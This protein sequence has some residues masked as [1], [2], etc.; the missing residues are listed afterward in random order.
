MR[1]SFACFHGLRRSYRRLRADYSRGLQ[2]RVGDKVKTMPI[3]VEPIE[4]EE[5][6]GEEHH[7]EGSAGSAGSAEAKH[8]DDAEEHEV[9]DHKLGA[10][11]PHV[12]LDPQRMWTIATAIEEQKR[13]APLP[14]ALPSPAWISGRA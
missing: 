4:P 6:H 13:S 10:P 8:D 11:D 5:H 12:W 1:K 2:K 14:L 9:H 7:A 3:D